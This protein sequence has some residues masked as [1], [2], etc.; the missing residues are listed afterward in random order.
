[1]QHVITY[2]GAGSGVV[3]VVVVVVVGGG[4]GDCRRDTQQGEAGKLMEQQRPSS[5]TDALEQHVSC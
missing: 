5:I 2:C 3:V 1:M 4:G